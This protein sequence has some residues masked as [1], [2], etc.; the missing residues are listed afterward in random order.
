MT[1]VL[2]VIYALQDFHKYAIIAISIAVVILWGYL[3]KKIQSFDLHEC[4]Y[5][6]V[7]SFIGM[8]YNP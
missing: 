6:V 2:T 5:R 4:L 1:S 8:S 3:F 7:T